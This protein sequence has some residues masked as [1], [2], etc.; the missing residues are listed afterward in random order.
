MCAGGL[1]QHSNTAVV[2]LALTSCLLLLLLPP[3]VVPI[4][5]DAHWCRTLSL[6]TMMSYPRYIGV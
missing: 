6:E 4:G 5:R 2:S 3:V 1:R